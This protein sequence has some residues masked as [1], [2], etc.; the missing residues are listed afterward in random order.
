MTMRSFHLPGRKPASRRAE[1]TLASVG[2]LALVGAAAVTGL[3]PATSSAS[4]HREAP[5]TAGDPKADNTDVYAFTS[6][7]KPD[8]VTLVANW[9]PFQEPNGGPNFY[10]F[11]NDARYNIKIDANGDGKP[12]TTYTWEFTDH[13]RDSADQFL[14]NTGVVKNLDDPTL[15]FRQTYDL[16]VTDSA[17]NR[18]TLLDDAPAAPSNVGKASMPDYASL[19]KQAVKQLPDGGQTMAGQTSDPFFADLRIFDL[20][21]GGNLSE[22]GHNTLAGYNVNTIAIQV[23]KKSVALKGDATRNPVIGVWSTTDRKGADVT[24]GK[25]GESADAVD[26]KGTD[27]Q[28]GGTPD[29]GGEDGW[30]QV[31][32]LGNPLVNEVVVP[33]KYKDA[34]N[35]LS[36]DKDA[37]VTP[38]VNAVKDPIVPKLVQSIYGVPAPAT[39]RNDLVEIFLTGICKA[40]GPIK[41]DLNAQQLNKDADKS[42]IVPAEELRLNMSVPPAAKPNRLGVLGEDLAGFPN[43]RRLNDDVVDIE[44]QALEG[45]AQTGKIVPALAA[46]DKV[47]TPYREPGDSFPYVALPNTAAVNQADA[48]HPDGGVGA[49]LGGNAFGGGFP[50]G[51]VAA[52]GGGALLACAGVMALRRRRAERA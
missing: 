33:L 47:D 49:G 35:A 26:G 38:V 36:P 23:P 29:K 34:F 13:I 21:Y 44:L 17:G 22:T 37:S 48:L 6:P 10:P 1:R 16:T 42:A 28:A 4:S 9:I 45:A 18:R 12:D 30:R 24:G 11:A 32:R 27:G 39:P 51:P 41:A 20:L 3:A 43:G 7:D 40:C 31:S 8:T 52:V 46:G 15:N 14:Y 2:T 19:R 50:V 5:M 25:G